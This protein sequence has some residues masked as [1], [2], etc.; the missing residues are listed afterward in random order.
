[1]DEEVIARMRG[2][3]SRARRV[4]E[5]AHNPEMIALLRELIEEAEADIRRM[6]ADARPAI[7]L[8]PE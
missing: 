4:I 8:K 7:P 2:R 3:I 6:E 1:M 5:M